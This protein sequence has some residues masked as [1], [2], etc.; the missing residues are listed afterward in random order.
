MALKLFGHAAKAMC[1]VPQ[2]R[3]VACTHPLRPLQNDVTEAA[4]HI[5]AKLEREFVSLQE[6]VDAEDERRMIFGL[7]SCGILYYRFTAF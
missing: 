2:D 1:Y 3:H 4:P 5:A 7:C 6:Y